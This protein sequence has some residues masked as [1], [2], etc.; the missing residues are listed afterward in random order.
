[1]NKKIDKSRKIQ[2]QDGNITGNVL[3]DESN[4]E[5]QITTNPQP[6]KNEKSGKFGWLDF[7]TWMQNGQ[8]IYYLISAIIGICLLIIHPK[9]FPSGSRKSIEKIP[10]ISPTPQVEIESDQNQ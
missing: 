3:G 4:I 6:P 5:G 7:L 1:M 10:E 2:N 8:I 9:L